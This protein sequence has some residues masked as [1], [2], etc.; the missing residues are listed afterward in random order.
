MKRKQWMATMLSIAFAGG[1]M[2]TSLEARAYTPAAVEQTAAYE[3]GEYIGK[4]HFLKES[5]AAS[6]CDSIVAREADLKVTNE[7]V[8]LKFY[9]AYPLPKYPEQGKDGTVKDV[10]L[11]VDG[12][13][14]EATS[15]IET[16]P[17]RFF[18]TDAIMMFGITAGSELQTQVLTVQLPKDSLEALEAGKVECQVFVNVAMSMNQSFYLQVSNITAVEGE[19][20]EVTI[21]TKR[22]EMKI[23][24]T[25]EQ[26]ISKPTYTITVPESV[27]LGTLDVSKSNEMEYSIEILEVEDAITVSVEENGTLSCNNQTL[28]FR[29]VFTTQEV[30]GKTTLKGSIVIDGDDVANAAAGNYTGTTTFYF[31]YEAK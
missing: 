2:A 14:Y 22:Q 12:N 11:I 20:E 31:S 1:M 13:E 3:A 25:I 9:I 18:D 15:D 7:G 8:E 16:K 24:A 10:K 30:S 26:E 4:I 23:T 6:L 29:N 17:T 21:E 28:A 5:G 19:K 27:E